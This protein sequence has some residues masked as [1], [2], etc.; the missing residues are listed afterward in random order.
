[1]KGIILKNATVLGDDGIIYH[2]P[3]RGLDRESYAEVLIDA[4]SVGGY[5][6]FKR[7]SIKPFIGMNV[8][9]SVGNGNGY[10]YEIVK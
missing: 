10:N 7:Q 5:G 1:M 9:F 3:L 8:T 4:K 2:L 6:Y